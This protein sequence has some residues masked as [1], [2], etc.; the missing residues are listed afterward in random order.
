MENL[1]C[2]QGGFQK[3]PQ[4]DIDV[5]WSDFVGC[6]SNKS[7]QAIYDNV[8]SDN[9]NKILKLYDN[10][11]IMEWVAGLTNVPISCKLDTLRY[12]IMGGPVGAIVYAYKVPF[13]SRLFYVA[14]FERLKNG[15]I[16]MVLKSIKRD[17]ERES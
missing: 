10:D 12:P 15:Q 16:Q 3:A 5:V 17:G 14:L 13:N 1:S 4:R 11:A 2:S 8:P 7:L 9:A 6:C